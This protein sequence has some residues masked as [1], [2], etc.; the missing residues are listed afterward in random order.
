MAITKKMNIQVYTW[1]VS[2][3][4]TTLVIVQY[5]LF[6]R[7]SYYIFTCQEINNAGFLASF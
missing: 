7:I 3:A 4:L 6:Q 5:L 1:Y 2:L